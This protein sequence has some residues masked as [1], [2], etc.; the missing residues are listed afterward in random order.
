LVSEIAQLEMKRRKIIIGNLIG[1]TVWQLPYLFHYFNFNPT[2]S[3]WSSITSVI[4]CFVWLYYDIR[5]IQFSRLLRKKRELAR[6]LNDE[7]IQAIRL[8]SFT[9]AFWVLLGCIVTL[10]VLSLFVDLKA[11]FVLHLIIIVGVIGALTSYLIF[12]KDY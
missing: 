11:Q 9:A 5:L 4:G 6:S 2:I 1:F 8:K 10:F 3:G 7:Y 12:D